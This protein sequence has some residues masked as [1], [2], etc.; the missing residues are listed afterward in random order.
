MGSSTSPSMGSPSEEVVVL[1]LSESSMLILLTELEGIVLSDGGMVDHIMLVILLGESSTLLLPRLLLEGI[2]S[3]RP[4]MVGEE[5]GDDSA[6]VEWWRLVH[7]RAKS[8]PRDLLG[9][10]EAGAP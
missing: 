3:P 7:A 10:I 6:K 1:L 2:C 4:E 5:S 8:R 9:S